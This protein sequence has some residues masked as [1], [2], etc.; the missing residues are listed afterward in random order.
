MMVVNKELLILLR[1]GD[2]RA[3]ETIYWQCS[4]QVYRFVCSLL[5]DKTQAE[6]ITQTVFLKLWEKRATIDPEQGIDAYLFTI[7]RHLV[8]KATEERLRSEL[9]VADAWPLEPGDG[10]MA[11][12]QLE[13]R[14][15]QKYIARL[16]EQLPPSRREIFRLSRYEHL[17]NKEIAAR[18]SI[19]EKTVETQ[20]YRSL[21][22][23]RRMLPKDE[24]LVILL[25]GG[26]M[27]S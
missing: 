4:R 5:Y 13:A 25:L 9:C 20:L 8:Y 26:F 1:R 19:S 18:L 11:E 10:G 23:L 22:F 16:V 3:F 27:M 6:D 21:Q 15:L 2:E 12:L 14:S 7:A 17:S 24:L